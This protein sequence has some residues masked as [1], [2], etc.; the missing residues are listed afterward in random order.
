MLISTVVGVIGAV[1]VAIMFLVSLNSS[2]GLM[3][4]FD[5][6]LTVP[7][8]VVFEIGFFGFGFWREFRKQIRKQK[9]QMQS[10]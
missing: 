9:D 8:L 3:S 5:N 7:F 1:P 4:V 2:S 10:E 6:R